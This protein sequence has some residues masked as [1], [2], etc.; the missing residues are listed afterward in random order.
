LNTPVSGTPRLLL[1]LEGFVLLV[2]A[3]VAY[4]LIGGSWLRFGL[5]L[6]VPDVGLAGYAA[7]PRVGA[8][9]YNALHTYM[10]PAALALLGLS[11]VLTDVWPLCLIWLAHI[12]MD[13]VLGL[14][15]KFPTAFGHT[16]LGTVGRITPNS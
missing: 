8:A 6:L 13:R 15:L 4:Q 12:G 16:H 7:N 10:A 5:L 1:R 14:G 11:G 3:V 9:A 2:A